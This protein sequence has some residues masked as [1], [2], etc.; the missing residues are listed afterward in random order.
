MVNKGGG[1]TANVRLSNFELLR[2][3]CIFGIVCMHA[4]GS[5]RGTATGINLV[6]GVLINS[7]FN[8]GVSIF[9]LIS[10]YFGISFSTNKYLKLELEVL[11]YSIVSVVSISAM[12]NSWNIKQIVKACMPVASGQYWYITS[13]MLLLIFSEYIN[14]VPEKLE[15]RDFE[16]LLFLML[17]VFSII[18]TIVQVHV[19]NDGGKGVANMLLMYFIGR[20]IRL[21]K[22]EEQKIS[23]FLLL[24]V[25][26]IV[27]GFILDFSLTMFRG[28]KGLY[29]PFARDCSCIIVLASVAIFMCFKQIRFYSKTVNKLAKHVVAVYLFE[30]AMRTAIGQFFDITL[31]EKEWYLFIVITVY[32]LAVMIGCMAVDMIRMPIGNCVEKTVNVFCEKNDLR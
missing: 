7:I 4:F 17:L 29:T 15:K 20:Y 16:K 28:G 8:T 31:Y 32:A 22:D 18:P 27:T 11:L 3:L 13:Y 24:G 14:R 25:G 23:R 9:V 26:M 19:M 1:G 5:F 30:G 6:Y 10:G 21:Y 2:L 12:Q